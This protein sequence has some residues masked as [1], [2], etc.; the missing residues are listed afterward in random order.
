[1]Y[2]HVIIFLPMFYLIQSGMFIMFCFACLG[3]VYALL[4]PL[5]VL[6]VVGVL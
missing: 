5:P 6:S 2:A 3:A 1:M 4:C